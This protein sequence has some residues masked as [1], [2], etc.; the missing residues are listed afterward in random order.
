MISSEVQRTL[1]KSPP[2]LWSELSDEAALA[3]H[4]SEFGQVRIARL[5]PEERIDWV[6]DGARGSILIK[7]S[8][9]GTRVTLTLERDRVRA[10]AD[11][12]P[13]TAPTSTP[14]PPKST[15]PQPQ[16][17]ERPAPAACAPQPQASQAAGSGPKPSVRE[18]VTSE[19]DRPAS[20]PAT[21]EP[22]ASAIP[23]PKPANAA[24]G[25][26]AANAVPELLSQP[27]SAAALQGETLRRRGFF[28]R[29]VSGWQRALAW[30]ERPSEPQQP[31]AGTATP[32]PA[33]EPAPEAAAEPAPEAAAEPA[34]GA[35]AEPAPEAAIEPAPGAAGE[36]APEAA[37]EPA[38]E[39][40]ATCGD[41]AE[42]VA[43][44]TPEISARETGAA[45]TATTGPQRAAGQE[46][47]LSAELRAAEEAPDEGDAAVLRAV[48]DSL[49]SAHHR[50]FSRA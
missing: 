1:V 7:P 27:E 28:A 21:A 17:S 20:E 6:T 46:Q 8:G 31:S 25:T 10:V 16:T 18:T 32:E 44:R 15:A 43:D 49:G 38:P 35:A 12:A 36:P 23:T 47:D 22:G 24:P 48:L 37:T 30:A 2:E 5:E 40:L 42:C 34:P 50:P 33:S 19:K 26:P 29:V 3:R 45:A 41:S 4:L 14:P 39:P 11:V 13:P 9:W